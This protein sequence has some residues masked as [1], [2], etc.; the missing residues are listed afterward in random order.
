MLGKLKKKI[1]E[2]ETRPVILHEIPGRVRLGLKV[3][4]RLKKENMPLAENLK[5]L[6]EDIPALNEIKLNNLSGSIVINYDQQ[7]TDAKG[8]QSFLREVIRYLLGYSDEILRVPEEELPDILV[9]LSMQIRDS[10]SA[11]LKFSPVKLDKSFWQL[12]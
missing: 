6:L 12:A 8:V 10:T 4:K 3:I 1:I 11:E 2:L 9:K 7:L 5:V